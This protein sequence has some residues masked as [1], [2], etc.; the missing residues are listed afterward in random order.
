MRVLI[1]QFCNG[2]K[3]G[4]TYNSTPNPL[5]NGNS[6]LFASSLFVHLNEHGENIAISKDTDDQLIIGYTKDGMAFQ[7]IVDGFFGGDREIIFTF[8]NEYVVSL[9]EQ[10]SND[11]KSQTDSDIVTKALIKTI[12][13]LRTTHAPY[14]EFTMSLAM[15]YQ[16][17]GVLF[18]AGFGIGDTGIVMKRLN[19]TIEQLVAHTETN[20]FKDG[21]DTYS[22]SNIDL[23]IRRNTI[24]NTKV[25]P[26]D[27]LVGYTYIYPE[28]EMVIEEFETESINKG[29]NKEKIKHLILAPQHF[30]DHS[31]LYT[32]ILAAVKE[33]QADL[34]VRAKM[35]QQHQRFGDDF[36]VGRLVIPDKLLIHQLRF[37][38]FL[39]A[40]NIALAFFIEREAEN[41][42][43]FSGS[44]K[45]IE[46]ALFYKNLIAK[47]QSD[48]LISLVVL[49]AMFD[50]KAENQMNDYLTKYLGFPSLNSISQMLEEL[51][52]NEINYL[53][54]HHAELRDL[55][56]NLVLGLKDDINQFI[57]NT[58]EGDIHHVLDQFLAN[59][60]P[61]SSISNTQ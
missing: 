2:V 38:G 57:S 51:I 9:M 10:Y 33:K 5:D 43:F 61:K 36:T 26:G 59:S 39:I 21:F 31:S 17:D 13:S 16:R 11:L 52:S 23:V 7:I 55:L 28:L 32:Q 15:T 35:S 8:V 44:S 6:S 50:S 29:S 49:L 14:A 22:Q 12:Y 48:C 4:Q 19:G 60:T 54:E 53:S 34:T 3:S 18:C 56:P 47:Y 42:G 46:K 20:G 58:S 37:N 25:E 1:T 45:R 40:I 30:N 27:E 41:H 24:F